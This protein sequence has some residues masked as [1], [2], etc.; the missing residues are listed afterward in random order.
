ME[1]LAVGVAVVDEENSLT[2]LP[3]EFEGEKSAAV[4]GR[5]L[6]RCSFWKFKINCCW[7]SSRLAIADID[8]F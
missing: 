4:V 5:F 2:R 3:V 8:G 1:A 7:R 6:L